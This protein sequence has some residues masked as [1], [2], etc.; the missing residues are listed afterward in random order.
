MKKFLIKLTVSVLLFSYIVLY[1]VDLIEFFSIIK[2]T[3]LFYLFLA[4]L[5]F[6]VG[7]Y[8][9]VLRWDIMFGF[10]G[11][12]SPGIKTL[13]SSYMVANFFN[14]FLPTRFGG[15]IVRISDTRESTGSTVRST[16]IVIAE[17]LNGIMVLF[18]FALFS[19]LYYV[20]VGIRNQFVFFVLGVGLLGV[21]SIA[22]AFSE[23]PLKIVSK[24]KFLPE[25]LKLKVVEFTKT[26][27]RYKKDKKLFFKITFYS[28]LLQLNVI[29]HYYF[30][31]KAL[32]LRLSFLSYFTFIPVLLVVLSI[33]ISVNGLGLR[34]G[35]LILMFKSFSIQPEFAFSFAMIDLF[36]MVI[37][38]L[39]GGVVFILRK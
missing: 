29:I 12:T 17:R 33:P 14:L 21:L 10:E 31:G 27:N 5:L 6:F 22:F 16:G 32:D 3:D 1:K 26:I 38:G 23:I 9:S 7:I 28:F 18:L 19:S 30:I 39:A 2:K 36:L 8:I 35:S 11:E 37:L 20:A 34:E 25:R 13:F 15:D 4:F 24:I